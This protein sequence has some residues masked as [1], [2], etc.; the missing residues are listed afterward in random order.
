MTGNLDARG[1]IMRHPSGACDRDDCYCS[2]AHPCNHCGATVPPAVLLCYG[3][4]SR[5]ATRRLTAATAGL[6][7]SLLPTPIRAGSPVVNRT[8]HTRR[9]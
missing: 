1:R 5:A 7:R 6:R 2:G 9:L 4:A 8:P 3:C